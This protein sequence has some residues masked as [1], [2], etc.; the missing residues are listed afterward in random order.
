MV[1]IK[2][3]AESFSGEISDV[4]SKFWGNGWGFGKVILDDT[5]VAAKV[6]GPLSG[7]R[8]GMRISFSGVWVNNPKYGAQIEIQSIVQDLPNTA[9]GVV[10]WL[11][12]VL[13]QIGPK[14][15]QECI[16]MFGV[17]GIWKTIE[18]N[19]EYLTDIPGITED[20]VVAIV[21]A[22]NDLCYTRDSEIE[23]FNLGL[24]KKEMPGVL[25][26]L[27][28]T[29]AHL[30]R[31]NPY[32]LYFSAG[33]TFSRTD[34]IGGDLGIRDKDPR[35]AEAVVVEEVRAACYGQGHTYVVGY[36]LYETMS[37]S[38]WTTDEVDDAL[39]ASV[40][41][42]RVRMNDEYVALPTLE[43]A[44]SCIAIQINTMLRGGNGRDR[45]R[46]DS[47]SGGRD[48]P[49][50]ADWDSDGVPGDR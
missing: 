46:L 44:E 14:R 39:D 2:Q 27:G 8:V 16:D 13:P 48:D 35:R 4:S 7:Y 41:L 29:A 49:P 28:Q 24:D 6:V 26:D 15:A 50:G 12:S 19:P 47:G 32:V 40:S 3:G 9:R 33:F 36:N 23:L 45:V 21:D 37:E 22:Y 31:E 18:E 1:G 43:D 10:R 42:G 20:R 17:P 30:I 38:G 5:K 34:R 25:H 11:Q